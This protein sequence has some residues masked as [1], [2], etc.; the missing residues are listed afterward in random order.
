MLP[1]CS[2]ASSPIPVTS[3][4]GWLGGWTVPTQIQ[5]NEEQSAKSAKLGPCKRFLPPVICSPWPPL[6][7]LDTVFQLGK[8]YLRGFQTRLF[9]FLQYGAVV[10]TAH[11]SSPGDLAVCSP[12]SWGFPQSFALSGLQAARQ[13]EMKDAVHTYSD[14]NALSLKPV[15]VETNS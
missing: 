3:L 6:E 15:D 2:L 1:V 7:S 8:G 5:E 11:Q 13:S 4:Y 12:V 9:T 14:W 10:I